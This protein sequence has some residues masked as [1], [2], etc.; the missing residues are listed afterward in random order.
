MPSI[1][2]VLKPYKAFVAALVILAALVNGLS[3]IIPK[4]ISIGIDDH[5]A[6]TLDL[7]TL[8]IQFLVVSF[9]IFILTYFQ[10]L[11]QVYTSER[12]ARDMRN[13]LA[14]KI[15]NLS[16]QQL[17]QEKSTK[18][19]TY[20]TSDIDAIKMFV[21][22]AV[23]TVVSS[24]VVVIG[25][26][27]LLFVINWKLAL[28][29]LAILP[30]IG[31]LFF[32]VFSRLGPLFKETQ[33]IIDKL[34]LI[35]S[36][37]VL[38]SA[39]VRVFNSGQHEYKKFSIVNTLSKENGLKILKYFSIIVPSIG[40]IANLASL[41]I[42]ALGGYFVIGGNMTLGDFTAFQSYVFILI[43]PI[44]MLGFVSSMISQAQASY[45]R[46]SELLNSPEEKEVGT[47]DTPIL[48]D[49]EFKNVSLMYGEKPALE[50]ASFSVKAGT[51][52][53]I[54]GPTAAGKTQLLYLLIG[55]IKPTTG[56]I[57]IDGKPLKDYS[58]KAIHSQIALVF[59][60]SVMFNLSLME[61][62]AFSRD[63][64][65]E[66]IQKAIETAELADFV[67]TLP[68][69]LE[70]IASERGTSLS[71]GQKQRIMLARALALNPQV[72]LL[73]DF[74]ARVDSATEKKIL[75]N[76]EKNYPGITIV[77]V[78]QKVRSVKH[79]EKIILLM[80]GEILAQGTHDELADT[81]AEYAQIL[82]S[83]KSTHTY[84]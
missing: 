12:V 32:V 59:Q 24:S 10:G 23:V 70:T 17:E 39:L 36:E 48:G 27:I 45:N 41:V 66:D 9:I 84:E 26:A 74:T 44:I 76:I 38:G 42:L 71:G 22:M 19:L 14:R 82:E 2:S 55:L 69:G 52:T 75:A 20:L 11:F 50:D 81:S 30:I 72:L 83:Q 46:I 54:L 43:F 61:N 31:I 58:K 29:V 73:D 80:E 18:L 25:A 35:I 57:L 37:S 40:I 60:D 7:Q 56:E 47:I 13:T 33:E 79:F 28:A 1:I 21:S 6:G 15:S 5:G 34:N 51:K 3:L 64:K 8:L 63:A 49:I 68:N 16:F 62:I 53:A 78:T 67:D 77:S 65:Q 4:L